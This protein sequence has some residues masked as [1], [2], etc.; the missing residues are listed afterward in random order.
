MKTHSIR[1][2]CIVFAD[3]IYLNQATVGVQ[4]IDTR[5][6]WVEN[7]SSTGLLMQ[8]NFV[9]N[10]TGGNALDFGDLT[11]TVAICRWLF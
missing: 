6:Y 10:T 9:T 3:L 2:K 7:A 8:L 4:I 5:V 11:D 1:R